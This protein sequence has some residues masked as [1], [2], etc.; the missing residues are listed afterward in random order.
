VTLTE[1]P[2]SLADNLSTKAPET[3][4]DAQSL[5]VPPNKFATLTANSSPI[6]Q[7]ACD[8]LGELVVDILPEMTNILP[9]A[10]KAP[11]RHIPYNI[12]DQEPPGARPRTRSI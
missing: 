7:V 8:P 10:P 4:A 11:P 3:V 6:F 2:Y 5:I 9:E 1:A 12:L